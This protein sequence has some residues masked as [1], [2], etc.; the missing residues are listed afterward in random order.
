MFNC[1]SATRVVVTGANG[2]IGSHLI[3]ELVDR[4][5]KVRAIVR[6]EQAAR[7]VSASAEI[8]TIDNPHSVDAWGTAVAGCDVVLHLI[9]LAHSA[10]DDVGGDLQK[11]RDVNVG[12]TDRVVDA[13]LR[14]GVHRLIYLSSIKAVGEGASEPYTEASECLPENPYGESK[15]EAEMLI[16]E[17]TRDASLEASI[18]RPPVVY[19]PGVKGNIVRMMK[20]VRSRLPL[21]IRCLKAKR[22]MVYVGNLTDA[23]CAMVESR[24]PVEGVY[25]VSDGEDPLSTRELLVELGRLMGKRVV[26]VPVPAP[27]LH[28]MGRLVGMGEEAGRLTRALI[29]RGTRLPEELGW[30][31]P[32]SMQEGLAATV[33]CF[34]DHEVGI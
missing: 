33:Q 1:I 20:L 18:V 16:L 31:P 6:S 29:T 3:D 27:L 24:S 22:S 30:T 11:F 10:A 2:F 9:G 34:A 23:L 8:F 13:C 7:N 5:H 17:R 28:A 4:G 25:H 14:N 15:R 12:I 32:H 26:E 19:G 21:P